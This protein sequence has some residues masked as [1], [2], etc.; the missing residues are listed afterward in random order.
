MLTSRVVMS[1]AGE[2]LDAAAM[3]LPLEQRGD[4]PAFSGV[5]SSV[6]DEEDRELLG[7]ALVDLD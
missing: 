3:D 7:S 6:L 4:R 1:V 5:L 2:L